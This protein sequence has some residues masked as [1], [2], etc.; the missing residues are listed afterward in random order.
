MTTTTT[1]YSTITEA[2]IFI[3]TVNTWVQGKFAKLVAQEPGLY[4][5]EVVSL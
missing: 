5:V 3:R 1:T 4:T 2:N